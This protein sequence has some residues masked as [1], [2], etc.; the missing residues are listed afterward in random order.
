[1][2][3]DDKEWKENLIDEGDRDIIKRNLVNLG[4]SVTPDVQR[5]VIYLKIND[6][7]YVF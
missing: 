5:Q 2:Q 4:C 1:M 3:E 7:S 6:G